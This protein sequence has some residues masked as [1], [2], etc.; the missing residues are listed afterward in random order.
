MGYLTL[1][2]GVHLVMLYVSGRA[3]CRRGWNKGFDV[4][5]PFWK[6]GRDDIRLLSSFTCCLR[7]LLS[8][9]PLILPSLHPPW[10]DEVLRRGAGREQLSPSEREQQGG[11]RKWMKVPIG[12]AQVL[13]PYAD[14]SRDKGEDS[15]HR[16]APKLEEE[17]E[18]LAVAN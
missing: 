4:W 8:S 9:Q 13:G 6:N 17:M 7:C 18:I 1:P 3:I 11:K 2:Q 10:R 14:S 15:Q 16:W 5:G 12:A